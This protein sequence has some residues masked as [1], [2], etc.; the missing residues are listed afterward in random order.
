MNIVPQRRR[1]ARESTLVH[2]LR[3]MIVNSDAW[4]IRRVCFLVR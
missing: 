4:Y 1:A 3:I 2:E